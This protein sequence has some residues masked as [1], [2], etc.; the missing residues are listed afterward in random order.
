MRGILVFLEFCK[1]HEEPL[2]EFMK[3]HMPKKSAAPAE[4][5]T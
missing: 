2:R 5:A 4:A 1:M 3:A